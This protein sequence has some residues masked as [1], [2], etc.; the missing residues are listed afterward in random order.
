M[1]PHAKRCVKA[2]VDIVIA[3]GYEAGVHAAWEPVHSLV[4][5]PAITR[6]V[7]IPVVG[8]RGF[9]DGATLVVALILGACGVQMGTRFIA[10]LESDFVKI[11]KDLVLKSYERDTLAS[12]GFAGPFMYLK[13]E[14]SIKLTEVT[15]KNTLRFFLEEPYET[16]NPEIFQVEMDGMGSLLGDDDDGKDKSLTIKQ[17]Q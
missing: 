17:A 6:A 9:C 7:D 2:G 14:A 5:L 15:L 8:V 4:L 3:S 13:N 11:W 12:T 10:T 16:I 1:V